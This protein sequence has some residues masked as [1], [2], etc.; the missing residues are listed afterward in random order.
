MPRSAVVLIG[1]HANRAELALSHGFTHAFT[2]AP[3]NLIDTIGARVIESES[4]LE[5]KG[6]VGEIEAKIADQHIAIRADFQATLLVTIEELVQGGSIST[7]HGT[8][9]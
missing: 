2:G 5:P 8:D 7:D 9:G 6:G 1:V 3:R 4:G